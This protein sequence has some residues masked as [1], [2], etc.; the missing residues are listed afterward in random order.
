MARRDADG[1]CKEQIHEVRDHEQSL[2]TAKDTRDKKILVAH[3]HL[4]GWVDSM[5]IRSLWIL[6]MG[7]QSKYGQRMPWIMIPMCSWSSLSEGR[8]GA[9]QME[10]NS[11]EL[12][13][14]SPTSQ[15]SRT[16]GSTAC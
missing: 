14:V 7:T 10:V 16:A 6:K 8:V 1:M 3:T 4:I 15:G 13:L 11:L 9:V 5:N 12:Q 2:D